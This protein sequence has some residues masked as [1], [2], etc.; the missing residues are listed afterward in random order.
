MNIEIK[1]PLF[2]ATKIRGYVNQINVTSQNIKKMRE[3]FEEINDLITTNNTIHINLLILL[4]HYTLYKIKENPNSG[5]LNSVINYFIEEHDA[6]DDHDKSEFGYM[7]DLMVILV[8]LDKYK[9]KSS[10]SLLDFEEKTIYNVSSHLTNELGIFLLGI[11]NNKDISPEEDTLIQYYKSENSFLNEIFSIDLPHEK[12][13]QHLIRIYELSNENKNEISVDSIISN[14]FISGYKHIIPINSNNLEIFKNSIEIGLKAG[15]GI[16]ILSNNYSKLEKEIFVS[17]FIIG[18]SLNK[19]EYNNLSLDQEFNEQFLKENELSIYRFDITGLKVISDDYKIED[20]FVISSDG[21]NKLPMQNFKNN[22]L[23]NNIFNYPKSSF[24]F[25]AHSE[26]KKHIN[27]FRFL[28]FLNLLYE[29]YC[30]PIF[31]IFKISFNSIKNISNQWWFI[32]EFFQIKKNLDYN[33]RSERSQF[34]FDPFDYLDFTDL[35]IRDIDLYSLPENINISSYIDDLKSYYADKIS[36]IEKYLK[37]YQFYDKIY[38]LIFINSKFYSLQKN[39]T[40]TISNLNCISFKQSLKTIDI[41]TDLE[42]WILIEN[43]LD[44]IYNNIVEEEQKLF[45][46]N[47]QYN[48]IH[49][50]GGEEEFYQEIERYGTIDG[51]EKILEFSNYFAENGIREKF[52]NKFFEIVKENKNITIICTYKAIENLKQILSSNDY[53]DNIKFLTIDKIL[54]TKS[55]LHNE[56]DTI[57]VVGNFS[58]KIELL[59]Q[60]KFNNLIYLKYE[61]Y[62]IKRYKEEST[63]LQSKKKEFDEVIEKNLES[64]EK[65]LAVLASTGRVCLVK[66]DDLLKNKEIYSG[67]YK[68]GDDK[69]NFESIIQKTISFSYKSN[70]IHNSIWKQKLKE[71]YEKECSSDMSILQKKLQDYKV[72]RE[73]ITLREWIYGE[74]TLLPRRGFKDI[75]QIFKC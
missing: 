33:F 40:N 62:K 45:L 61:N 19:L 38:Y 25:I 52:I 56:Y 8:G 66:I 5:I 63:Q 59:T 28:Y 51:I 57:I 3:L 26:N 54:T 23:K 46:R 17:G 1:F 49:S 48:Y 72:G 22:Y 71:F 15:K 35:V 32:E 50:L 44:E 21:S 69:L 75:E 36:N 10:F 20:N 2:V 9:T 70:L 64:T 37:E 60:L 4:L 58:R 13:I 30:N 55:H 27:N 39:K 67:F 43:V 31:P 29:N 11:F 68:F 18:F 42:F 7:D 6:I 47:F 41:E 16:N 24:F 65:I 53:S 74:S 34:D 12:Y 14:L 73:I